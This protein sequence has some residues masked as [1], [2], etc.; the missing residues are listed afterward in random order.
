MLA[1]A[2][3]LFL[4]SIG[5]VQ[6]D[7]PEPPVLERRE[8]DRANLPTDGEMI[9]FR[10]A[11]QDFQDEDLVYYL[12]LPP[13]WEPKASEPLTAHF[14]TARWV[15]VP[16]HLKAGL[17]G[18]LFIFNNG[19]GSSV[20]RRPFEDRGRWGRWLQDM[21]QAVI[22]RGAPDDFEWSA[23]DVSSFSAGYGAVR[24]IVKE[25]DYFAKL[26]RV[27][28]VDSLYGGL[29]EEEGRVPNPRDV[30]VWAPLAMSAAL[31][32]KTFLITISEVSTPYASSSECAAA[33]VRHLGGELEPAPHV[34]EI[35]ETMTEWN[36]LRRYDRGNFHVWLYEGAEAQAHLAHTRN[37]S[38]L[39]L[40]LDEAGKP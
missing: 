28:L 12:Y 27:A 36:L 25:P 24:E 31:G 29:L 1:L 20:Y 30:L 3:A 37:L 39:W 11:D 18:P 21:R 19:A 40:A 2:S 14:H 32:D 35:D 38:D 8:A 22:E 16:E 6:A 4:S 10:D 17:D 34:V 26:R 7:L 23:V 5:A 33:I 13:E 15:S 9:E